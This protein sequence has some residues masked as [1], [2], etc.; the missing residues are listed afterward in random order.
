MLKKWK[1]ISKDVLFRM[2]A[3]VITLKNDIDVLKG[4]KEVLRGIIKGN[5][6]EIEG[7]KAKHE[8]Q[9]D[10]LREGYE[11][12]IKKEQDK[13]TAY[14]AKQKQK[15]IE[16]KKKWMNGYPGETFESK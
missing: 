11:Q 10:A 6:E 4:E 15:N 3:E 8:K 5:E 12:E 14:L 1:I 7:L 16:L 9:I 2:R 13:H